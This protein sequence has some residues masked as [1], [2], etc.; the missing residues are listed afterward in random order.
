MPRKIP[1]YAQLEHERRFL[2]TQ[3]PE[4]SGVAFRL[5]EDLYIIGSRLRLRKITLGDG[6][7]IQFKLCKKYPS[8]DRLSVPIV[9][10]YLTADEHAVLSELPGRNIRKRRYSIVSSAKSLSL[11][12]FEGQLS[13]LILCEVET[14]SVA[15]LESQ[16]FPD[17]V[18]REVT[19]DPFFTGGNL[20]GIDARVLVAKLSSL[21]DRSV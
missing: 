13:G 9:N 5:I 11:D 20:A 12:V 2:I 17:W 14:A 16:V 15:E 18:R 19:D 3:A 4:L 8:D 7:D 10:T 21:Y 6:R 1:K